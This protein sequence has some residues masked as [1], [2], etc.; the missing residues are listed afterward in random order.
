MP[1][2]IRVGLFITEL[3]LGGAEKS[4]SLLARGLPRDEFEVHVACLFGPEPTGT[5]LR[6]EGIPVEDFRMAGHLDFRAVWRCRSWMRERRLDI[7][8][9]FLF[10]AN[11]V[12]RLARPGAGGPHLFHAQRN[13]GQES[14]LQR[15]LLRSTHRRVSRFTAVSVAAK[16]HLVGELGVSQVK[17]VVIRNGID[18]AE[19][20]R[21][22][23]AGFPIED[24][25]PRVGTIGHMR[26][27]DSKGYPT[28]GAAARLVGKRSPARFLAC[29]EV[30]EKIRGQVE[31]DGIRLLGVRRDT[32][33]FLR[34]LQIY[35]QASTREGLP[36]AILEAMA[37]G[38]PVVATAVGGVPEVVEDGVTGILV[39]PEE[40]ARLADAILSLL[41]SPD[42]A[43]TMGEAGRARIESHFTAAAMVA[44]HHTL[45]RRTVTPLP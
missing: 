19:F 17:V 44:A 22:A 9:A 24:G 37:A 14:P 21:E 10:H 11:F 2:R 20:D 33:A 34:A 26:R 27:D 6:D 43:R 30:D 1:R 3:G 4:L 31:A 40:P 38:L 16:D 25:A 28:L 5:L 12:A 41:D 8:H 18:L 15:L 23:G 42:R 36:N 32:P 7:V 29:G 13:I 45:Y 35:V 39:P